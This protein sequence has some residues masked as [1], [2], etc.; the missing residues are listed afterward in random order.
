M[1]VSISV[2]TCYYDERVIMMNMWLWWMCDYDDDDDYEDVSYSMML[3][4]FTEKSNIDNVNTNTGNVL[5]WS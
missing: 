3:Q 5:S 2:I 4:C 1:N